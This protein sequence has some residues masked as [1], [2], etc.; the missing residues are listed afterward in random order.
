MIGIDIVSISR[1]E[2]M[3]EEYGDKFLARFLNENEMHLAKNAQSAAGLWAAKEATAKAL[4]SG[5]G[6]RLGFH[7][8]SVAK[9]LHGAPFVILSDKASELFKVKKVNVSI[10]H[11]GGFSAAVALVWQC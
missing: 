7:D 11:D 4:G 1:I 2:R 3:M 6:H 5:I 9:N 10:T 8:M